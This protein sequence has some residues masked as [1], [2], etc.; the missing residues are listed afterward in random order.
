MGWFFL[1]MALYPDVQVLAQKELDRVIGTQGIPTFEYI[2][3]LPY[4]QALVGS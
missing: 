4:I 1:A 3:Q 2:D